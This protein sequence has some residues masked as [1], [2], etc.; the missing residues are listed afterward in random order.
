M[1]KPSTSPILPAFSEAY[2]RPEVR[3]EIGPLASWVPSASHIIKPYVAETLPELF[4]DPTCSVL[5]ISAERTFWEKV[6]TLH[7]EAHRD[8]QFPAATRRHYYDLCKLAESSMRGRRPFR[9]RPSCRRGPIKERFYPSK[10]ARYDLAVPGSM[11][12]LPASQSQLKEL[13]RDYEDMQVMLFGTPPTFTRVLD[14]LRD[15]EQGINS[16]K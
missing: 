12:L 8:V 4:T 2:I 9:S 10:W 3:L 7:Q 15:L 13:E 16:L 6:T 14:V 5:T 11:K 1:R